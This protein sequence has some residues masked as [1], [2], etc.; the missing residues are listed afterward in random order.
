[1]PRTLSIVS[2]G[3]AQRCCQIQCSWTEPPNPTSLLA[4]VS[5]Y[6]GFGV[7]L[8]RELSRTLPP[9]FQRSRHYGLHA[10]PTYE[11]LKGCL[12]G[13]VKQ[14]GATVR[15]V[16]QILRALLQ[17]EPYCCEACSGTDFQEEHLAPDPAY[18]R[19]HVL[20][21]AQRSPPM[22]AQ[23]APAGT[24]ASPQTC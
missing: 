23:R 7:R 16:I 10:A 14:E 4:I 20:G 17:E 21:R 1:M 6:P 22:R 2:A 19:Y 15:T 9:Y 11:R 12:P 3:A 18:T 13:I 8:R 5:A 24:S